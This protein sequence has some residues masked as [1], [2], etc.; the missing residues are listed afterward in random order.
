MPPEPLTTPPGS[1]QLVTV[2]AGFSHSDR[3]SPVT[4]RWI[5]A[6]RAV[7]DQLVLVFDQ[8]R[9]TSLEAS[10]EGDDSLHVLMER[11]GAYDF[12]SYQRGLRLLREQGL[13]DHASHLLLCNDSVAGPMTDLSAVISKMVETSVVEPSDRDESVPVWGLSDCEL[14]SPHLQSYFLLMGKEVAQQPSIVEFFESVV[15]QPSRH[16]VIQAYELGFSRLL[17]RLGLKWRAWLPIAEMLDPRN[18]ERMGNSTAYPICSLEASSPVVKL[19]A[20]KDFAA[21]M[22]GLGRTCRLLAQQQ[23]EL[24]DQLWDS[25]PHRRLWQEAIPVAVL[26]TDADLPL[27]EE[28]VAW[29]EDHPHPS[30]KAL[31]AVSF[32]RIA[33]RAEL[34]R[35]F[36]K[37]L[38]DGVLSILICDSEPGT[39]QTLLQLL[40]AA[41]TDW[42]VASSSALWDDRAGLQL[43]L[44]RLA[45]NLQWRLVPGRPT[46][47]WREDCFSG[48]GLEALMGELADPDLNPDFDG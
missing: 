2:M 5:R 7:S 29:I 13:L 9:L 3:L 8:D 39:V 36:K 48:E 6:L 10:F 25:S 38:E 34:T 41:G 16:D 43:Q 20:L 46:L 22:D 12:G 18:G 24:W 27:L 42:V 17:A 23:P 19:R 37:A 4:E 33:L 45:G 47:R 28:R 40:A 44:R 14:Y 35:R 30:L 11:H 21:N 1:Y 15:P 31:V 32:N 26:L